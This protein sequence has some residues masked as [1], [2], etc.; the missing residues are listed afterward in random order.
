M[1]TG[2]PKSAFELIDVAVVHL[3]GRFAGRDEL[4]QTINEGVEVFRVVESRVDSFDNV[5]IG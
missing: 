4:L 5:V 3:L 1:E 2:E